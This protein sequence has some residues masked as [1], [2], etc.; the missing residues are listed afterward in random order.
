M[1]MAKNNHFEIMAMAEKNERER[2]N[3]LGTINLISYFDISFVVNH[4]LCV[5]CSLYE[6]FAPWTHI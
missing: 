1:D 6:H 4:D 3:S 2:E 5:C